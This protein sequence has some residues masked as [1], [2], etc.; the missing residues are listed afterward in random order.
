MI[1]PIPVLK[2][3]LPIFFGFFHLIIF[4]QIDSTTVLTFDFNSHK[5]KEKDA[6]VIPRAEGVT[7]TADRFG[8]EQSAVY[9]HGNLF[10][11]LNLSS[12]KLLKPRSGSIS[13]WINIDRRVY[14]GKGF[15]SNPIIWTKNGIG[16]D[17]ILAYSIMYDSHSKRL[18]TVL[19][20]DSLNEAIGC[21]IDTFIFGKWH[22]LGLVFNDNYL[23][24]YLNGNLQQKVKKNFITKYLSTDSVM[25]GHTAN[26][27]NERYSQG[28]FDDIQIFHRCLSDKEI[29]NLYNAPNPN[30]FKNIIIEILKYGLVI[31]ILTLTIIALIIRNKKMLKRQKEQFELIN[32]IT[33]LELKVVKAQMNPHFISNC[34]AAIQ[35]LIFKNNVDEAGRYI[36]KFSFFLRQILNYSNKNFITISEE[37]EIIKLNIELEQLR[38]KNKFNFD[39]FISGDIQT[40]EILIPALITQPFIENAIWHGL[41]Q[42]E[43]LRKPELKIS[44]SMKNGLPVIEI[45]DNG[46]GRDLKKDRNEDSKGTKLITDKI[47][48]LNKLYGTKNYKLEI[49]DLFNPE[50]HQVGTKVVIQLDIIKE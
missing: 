26:T 21:S 4:S 50:K 2:V 11:Y 15:D 16:D 19:S 30:K 49:I 10:S 48:S 41:L 7:L 45:V 24:F 22:H 37:I 40:K 29:N 33:E 39:V 23:S 44:I 28:I 3:V 25:I 35:D 14:A 18:L 47:E 36:A 5:I 1:I 6:K 43:N 42:L 20:K 32:K 9:I 38:F 31:L 8:N 46:I 27:K 13:L 34:L 17:F 12:S